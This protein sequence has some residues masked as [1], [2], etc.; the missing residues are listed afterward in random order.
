MG[1]DQ[2]RVRRL[3]LRLTGD[4]RRTIMRFFWPASDERARKIVGRVMGL[5]DD[6]VT[7]RLRSVVGDFSRQHPDLDKT[8]S[9]H[10]EEAARRVAVPGEPSRERRALIGAYFTMEYAFESAALFNPS[11]VPARDQSGLAPGSVRFVMSLRAI[12]EGHISS[13][14]FRMGTIDRDGEVTIEPPSRYVRPLRIAEDR[15]YDRDVFRSKLVEMGAH[16]PAADAVLGKLTEAFTASQLFEAIERTRA[17]LSDPSGFPEVAE[18]MRWLA[19]SNYEARFGSAVGLTELAVFPLGEAE[20][21]GI[22]DMRLVRFVEDDGAV[23][24]YGTYTAFNGRTI[25]PHLMESPAPG[26]A[27][28]HTLSGRYAQNKGMALFP[29]KL[30][31]AYLMIGRIDGENLYLLRSDN[32]RFWNDAVRIQ[33]PDY[34]WQFVQI[35]NCGSPIETDAGWLL[36]T[37][38]VG[39]MRRYCIGASL[40]DLKDPTKVIGQLGEPL[41]APTDEER[42]GYVPNVVYSC[43]GMVHNELLVIPYG[44]SDAATGVAVVP[45]DDVLARLRR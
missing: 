30:D 16:A 12:G 36:L 5:A 3:S 15:E 17:T 8:L 41:L 29:R 19:R 2:L 38:G 27:R 40:L 24:Y 4:A 22:E 31:G 32:V 35:G 21:H 1:E 13:I 18:N 43:G 33:E 28:V 11:M 10:Y 7:L 20:S 34:A 45:L 14:V 42:S 6:E 44:I 23:R 26:V 39:P 25:L 9:A 37:H